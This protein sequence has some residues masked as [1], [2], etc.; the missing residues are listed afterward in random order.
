VRAQ[1]FSR[2]EGRGR[3]DVDKNRSQSTSTHNNLIWTATCS[4]FPGAIKIF[5]GGGYSL[6]TAGMPCG[7]P[8]S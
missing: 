6:V 7:R 5:N 2:I 1:R 8:E 3:T 4:R